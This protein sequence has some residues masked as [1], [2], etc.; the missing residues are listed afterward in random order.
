M[1]D[2]IAGRYEILEI[3]GEGSMGRTYLARD[4]RGSGDGALVALKEMHPSRLANAKDLQLFLREAEILER[5]SHPQI[6]SYI[7]SFHLGEGE[8]M[9]FVLVQ[10]WVRGAS[11]RERLDDGERYTVD[12]LVELAAELLEIMAYLHGLDPPVIHRDIKPDN[13]V[14]GD[15]GRPSL[16]DF[17]A[18]REVVRLTMRGGST[19]I[20]TYGYMPPEQLMG[21]A[22][23]ATDLYAIGITMLE[24]LTRRTPRDLRGEDTAR[25]IEGL[26]VPEDLRR[27]LGR[28]CA[29]ALAERYA[30]ASEVLADLEELRSGGELVYAGQLEDQISER[31]RREARALEEASTPGVHWGYVLGLTITLVAS[32][33]AVLFMLEAIQAAQLGLGFLIAAPVSGVGLLGCFLLLARR[34]HFDAWEPPAPGWVRTRAEITRFERSY[35]DEYNQSGEAW[36]LFYRFSTRGG[37][38][39][40]NILLPG[41]VHPSQFRV[42]RRFDVYYPPGEPQYNEIEDFIHEGGG[43]GLSTLFDHRVEHTPE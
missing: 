43:E 26:E 19:I 12:A 23:P 39:E 20:G 21:R 10:T 7:D 17:G 42:G 35:F 3:L 37:V 18:V 38:F 15:D 29:P 14:L 30:E 33:A 16:V 2:E 6:P 34:Y 8:A 24:C 41:H 4:A 25:M 11:L 5:I 32:T 40:D 36:R 31:E 9:R 28:L 27:V 13:I 22:L 1:P